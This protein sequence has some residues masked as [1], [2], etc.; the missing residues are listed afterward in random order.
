MRIDV[1]L[2]VGG[3]PDSVIVR[4]S[5]NGETRRGAAE[6]TKLGRGWWLCTVEVESLKAKRDLEHQ[7]GALDSK[8]SLGGTFEDNI[9]VY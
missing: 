9:T 8:A 7:R 3:Y 5:A 6:R 1:G 2:K 4:R